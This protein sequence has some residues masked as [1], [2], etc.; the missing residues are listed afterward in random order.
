MNFWASARLLNP[1]CT[2]RRPCKASATANVPSGNHGPPAYQ[3]VYQTLHAL[4]ESDV[5]TPLPTAVALPSPDLSFDS[6][7]RP[8]CS[9]RRSWFAPLAIFSVLTDFGLAGGEVIW[10]GG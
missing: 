1:S 7:E 10:I 8:S 2:M 6:V 9:R 3:A 5:F 4:S